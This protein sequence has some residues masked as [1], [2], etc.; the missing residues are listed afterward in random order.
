MLANS[1]LFLAALKQ[2]NWPVQETETALDFH[3]RAVSAVRLQ[4]EG[5]G[6]TPT[7]ETI[8]TVAG[9]LVIFPHAPRLRHMLTTVRLSFQVYA[10]ILKD[11]EKWN[12][13]LQGLLELVKS[14]PG[15]LPALSQDSNLRT[16]LCWYVILPTKPPC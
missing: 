2:P 5:S 4:L 13:Q 8:G 1:A 6:G 14:Y 3:Q 10:D 9:F 11:R 16:T 12:T 7:A 15:G